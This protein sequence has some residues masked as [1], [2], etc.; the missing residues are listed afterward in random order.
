MVTEYDPATTEG[1]SEAVRVFFESDEYLRGNPLIAIRARLVAELLAGIREGRILDLGCGDGGVSRPLLA[2][3]NRLTLVDFSPAMLDRARSATPAGAAAEFVSADVLEFIPAVPYDA[4]LCIG[5][6]A[7]LPAV[8]PMIGRLAAALK[9]GGL[10]VVQLT[11]TGT[12]IGRARYTYLRLRSRS[13]PYRLNRLTYAGVVATARRHGL[14]LRDQ[15]RYA[16]SLPGTGHLSPRHRLRLEAGF[17]ARPSLA[18]AGAEVLISFQRTPS[19]EGSRSAHVP[20]E[21]GSALCGS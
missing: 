7:H 10:C 13:A 20:L 8:E 4:V 2:C 21:R 16:L 12:L 3:A 5:V 6:L 9:P 11:D 18:R 14:A 15:R 1:R 17:A 19:L